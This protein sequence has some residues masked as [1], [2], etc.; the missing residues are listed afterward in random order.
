MVKKP[1]DIVLVPLN[2][3]LSRMER[4]EAE[5]YGFKYNELLSAVPSIGAPRHATNGDQKMLLGILI[6][7]G[8]GGAVTAFG[9]GAWVIK[10]VRLWQ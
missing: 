10:N 2:G 5:K 9:I 8:I 1:Q 6:G 3:S 4:R 7:V